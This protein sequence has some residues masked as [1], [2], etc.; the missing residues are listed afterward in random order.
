MEP[1]R[2]VKNVTNAKAN[3]M[4]KD[5]TW[6]IRRAVE[7]TQRIVIEVTGNTRDLGSLFLYHTWVIFVLIV[8]NVSRNSGDSLTTAVKI[9]TARK[10]VA[11]EE[12]WCH[13]KAFLSRLRREYASDQAC[14]RS[15]GSTRSRWT[16]CA[17]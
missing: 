14:D 13:S 1:R 2:A 9:L 12:R 16:D 3:A 6:G 15:S 8:S 17:D 4:K 11:I 7:G 5:S 10:V